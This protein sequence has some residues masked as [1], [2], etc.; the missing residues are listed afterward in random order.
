M[1]IISS[2]KYLVFKTAKSPSN[3]DWAYVKRTN[4]RVKTDSAVVITTFVKYEGEYHFLFLK[5]KRPPIYA[6]NKAD[7]CLESPAGLIGDIDFSESV[8][9]CARKELLE[10]TGFM[11]EKMYVELTNSS[12]SAG[13]SSET[14]T[15]ITAFVEDDK[16][17]VVPTDDGGIIAD[18]FYINTKDIY[19]Y[20]N[21]VNKEKISI[22]APTVCGIFFALRRLELLTNLQK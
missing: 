19:N 15:Y 3:T 20:I 16:M 9:D 21:D 8:L 11:A 10:E 7:F 22:S 12:T 13:L 5:T 2:T 6:E 1:T 4:D 18:R 14:L 17:T